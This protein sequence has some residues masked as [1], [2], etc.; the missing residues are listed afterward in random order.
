KEQSAKGKDEERTIK[1]EYL[2]L[3]TDDGLVSIPMAQIQKLKLVNERL[4]TE[5]RQALAVLA[6]GH[7][8]Q[9]KTV[10]VTF[11][12]KGK[13]KVQISYIAQAPVWKTSYRLVLDEKEPFLQGWAIVENTSDEDWN[14]VQLSLVSGRP[15]SFIMDLYQP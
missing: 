15:I 1:V 14:D 7:D 3:L 10:S 6:H 12:G 4:D 9:K 8:T 2:N 13:R 11:D 5:S